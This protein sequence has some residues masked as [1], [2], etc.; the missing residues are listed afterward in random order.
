MTKT[1]TKT[2]TKTETRMGRG[3]VG[4]VAPTPTGYMH[5]GHA[6]TF[7]EAQR[8]AVAAGGKLFLRIE[9]LDAARCKAEF[10]EALE[11]DLS[12]AGLSWEPEVLRQSERLDWFRSMLLR[13]RNAG[14]VYPCSCSRK[15][16]A[17]AIRAPH[18][19]GLEP[20][21]PGTCRDKAFAFDS[22][23]DA[24]AINWRFRVPE[25]EAIAFVD[26][27]LGEQ[28]FV[29]GR[30]FGD[31]LVWRKDG[32]PSYE[33]AVV[34]DDIAQGVTEVVRGEDLLASTARQL[35][36]YRALGDEAPAFYHCPLILDTQGKRL[37][38]RAGAL[39]LRELRAR[40]VEPGEL[41]GLAG[42]T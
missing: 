40:G 39:G 3:Y 12:W 20:L 11:E 16:V 19:E 32:F 31:F 1:R 25:G 7:L 38:K 26:G 41:V 36:L 21:Y 23:A 4:R 33:L 29:A 24:L 15:D 9:D 22:E 6:C 18:A 28:R 17:E 2:K 34:A 27:R 8:R 35:L 5:L 30:D 14:V 37:A 13:L 10:V 42:R